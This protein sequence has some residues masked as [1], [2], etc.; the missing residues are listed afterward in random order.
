VARFV[1]GP[2][3]PVP[4][5][6][7]DWLL[8]PDVRRLLVGAVPPVERGCLSTLA[9]SAGR[10]WVAWTTAV[11]ELRLLNTASG[12]L[13]SLGQGCNP[14]FGEGG[15]AYLAAT[16]ADPDTGDYASV[17]VVRSSPA[18]PGAVWAR[19]QLWVV[20]WFGTKLLYDRFG[21][22]PPRFTIVL[23][24]SPYRGRTVP[25]AGQPVPGQ[26]HVVAAKPDGSR[27]LLQVDTISGKNGSPQADLDVVDGRSLRI[28][29]TTHPHGFE[30]LAA[31]VWIGDDIVAPDGLTD[32]DSTH[33][34]PGLVRLT[35]MGN[36]VTVRANSVGKTTQDVFERFDDLIPTG[37]GRLAAVHEYGQ[38]GV[39][40][41]CTISTL[42][43]RRVLTLT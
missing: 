8:L 40:L 3:V 21:D 42:D 9:E 39:L 17:I 30:G 6:S 13:W 34:G 2:Q 25:W 18:G 22:V 10:D 41:S 43:C 7:G 5:R 12:H 15:L 28:L 16:H 11:G 38:G 19:G 35:V 1:R 32:G 29:S 4:V 33:P 36:Q 27:L 37:D 20:G 26:A 14:V 23:A 31:G 24:A